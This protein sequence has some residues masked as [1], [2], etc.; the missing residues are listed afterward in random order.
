[1]THECALALT[2]SPTAPALYVRF[3]KQDL[4]RQ[5]AHRSVAD[6]R[7]LAEGIS[8]LFRRQQRLVI[9]LN[10]GVSPK[11][12]LPFANQKFTLAEFD[13]QTIADASNNTG[14][15]SLSE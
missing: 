11:L 9:K 5:S 14:T 3:G 8:Q 13:F 7:D 4:P 10:A 6:V 1:M 15:I 2:Y 12:S